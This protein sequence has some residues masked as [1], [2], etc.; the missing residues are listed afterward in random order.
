L[1]NLLLEFLARALRQEEE[2]KGVQIEKEVVKLY[3]FED[4]MIL[5]KKH[6]DIINS[7][8]KVAGYKIN[9]FGL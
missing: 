5:Y 2:I 3:L 9:P 1:F 8:S 4:N 7:F 6:L